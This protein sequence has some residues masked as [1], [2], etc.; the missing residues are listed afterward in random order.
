MDGCWVS[1]QTSIRD[2]AGARIVRSQTLDEQDALADRITEL[3]PG[4]KVIDRREKASSGYRAVHVV[5]RIGRCDVEIQIRT[6]Y[7]D[8]WAQ[9][10]EGLGD[11]WGRAIR[12]GGG[13]DE[14]N[15]LASDGPLTRAQV[16]EGDR[17]SPL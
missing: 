9:V 16:V 4:A 1:C 15:R 11:A 10:M 14:A 17:R 2:L 12:Y 7:Q 13:P 8:T 3:W 6:R 5:P